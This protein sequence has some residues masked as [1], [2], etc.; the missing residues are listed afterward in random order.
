MIPQKLLASAVIAIAVFSGSLNPLAADTRQKLA[1]DSVIEE[2]KER[3]VLRVGMSMFIPW[4][5]R[6]KDGGLIGF[7]IDVAKK[8]AADMGVGI[9]F[10][11]TAWSRI[12]PA[13]I[14]GKFDVIISGMSITPAR[15]LS[16][17]FTIPYG[18]S[19]QQLVAGRKLAGGM[20]VEE[21]NSPKATIVCRLG[22]TPCA[23]ALKIFPRANIRRFDDDARALKEVFNGKAH[24]FITSAP[25]PRF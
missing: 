12:I 14:A 21:F 23:T 19:G 6:A 3:K 4:A 18:H 25:K 9:E 20:I 1:G 11:P 5:M 17:N 8:V 13:L 2:I 16:V 10:V 22:S 7:E 15:N 24:A